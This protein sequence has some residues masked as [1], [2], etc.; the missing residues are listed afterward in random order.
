MQPIMKMVCEKCFSMIQ[1][2]HVHDFKE[3][4]CGDIFID[5][6]REYIRW[7]AKDGAKYHFV[8]E[9]NVTINPEGFGPYGES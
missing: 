1:S 5:G 8:D 2:I 4:N 7:G 6:G 9:N 3:C